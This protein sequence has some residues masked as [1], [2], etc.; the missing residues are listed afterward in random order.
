[1]GHYHVHALSQGVTQINLHTTTPLSLAI[2]DEESGMPVHALALRY[3][4]A[5]RCLEAWKMSDEAVEELEV[6]VFPSH[7]IIWD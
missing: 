7:L 6:A 1:M 5:E 3:A 2:S 4:C